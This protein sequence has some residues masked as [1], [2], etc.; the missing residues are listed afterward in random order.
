MNHLLGRPEVDREVRVHLA[1][2]R[3]CQT[4]MAKLEREI[5]S[6]ALELQDQRAGFELQA[7][8]KTER[9]VG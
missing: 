7:D 3:K 9:A 8:A 4:R 2:C 1:R 6:E 5:Q